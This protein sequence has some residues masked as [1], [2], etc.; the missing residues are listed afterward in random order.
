MASTTPYSSPHL[1]LL[2]Q[3]GK[4]PPPCALRPLQGLWRHRG[5]PGGALGASAD[6]GQDSGVGSK[7]LQSVGGHLNHVGWAPSACRRVAVGGRVGSQASFSRL[8]G[9]AGERSASTKWL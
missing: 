5:S 6:E 3:R 2:V 7:Q 8:T 4:A 1:L 9:A